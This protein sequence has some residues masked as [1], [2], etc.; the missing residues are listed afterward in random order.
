MTVGKENPMKTYYLTRNRILY[1]RRN[2]SPFNLLIFALFFIL[3]TF[4]KTIIVCLVSGD[5]VKM[6]WF[7]KGVGYNLSHSSKSAI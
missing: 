1:M 7:L 6:K 4:P 5:F 3:F 2:S